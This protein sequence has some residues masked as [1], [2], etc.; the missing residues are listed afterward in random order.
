MAITYPNYRDI[1]IDKGTSFSQTIEL[2][3]PFDEY[4]FEGSIK[5]SYSTLTGVPIDFTAVTNEPNK[6]VISVTAEN[7]S[8]LRR[9]RGVY[10]IFAT[11]KQTG[12]IHKEREGVA[13]YSNSVSIAPAPLPPD[14]GYQILLEDIIDA[15]TAAAANVEDFIP[16]IV[17]P[18]YDD[19]A[20]ADAD[21]DLLS[22]SL[23]KTV[24]GGRTIF[25]KP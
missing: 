5:S 3:V 2:G 4:D 20:E 7:T 22:G 23:Y 1:Y 25:Q 12:E 17:F 21:V 14:P 11:N 16:S 8:L 13:H 24:L 10:D 6:T 18:I 9:L 15:G 19:D